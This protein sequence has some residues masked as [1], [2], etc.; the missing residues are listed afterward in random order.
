[1]NHVYEAKLN[2]LEANRDENALHPDVRMAWLRLCEASLSLGCHIFLVES[3]RTARRQEALYAQGRST[4]GKIVTHARAGESWHET[5]R[6]LDFA[7]RGPDPWD[8]AH[9]WEVI[10]TCAEHLGFTWGGRWKAPKTDRPHLQMD[11]RGTMTLA[12]ALA[13][14]KEI[15]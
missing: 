11:N 1:V 5:R 8:N 3:Y 12:A 13:A 15:A 4:P 9:P 10:G 6:A 14:L 2:P 7:F